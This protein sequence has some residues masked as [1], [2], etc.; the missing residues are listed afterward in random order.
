MSKRSQAW[1]NLEKKAAEKLFGTRLVRGDD[2]GLS[3]LDVEHDWLAIDCKWRSTL[4]TASWFKKLEKDN[5]KIYGK[6]R[7]VPILVIKEKNMRSELVVIDIDDFVRIV[8]D[9]KYTIE[10]K[11][12]DN[13]EE[14]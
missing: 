14:A 9:K 7:K 11:E 3:M 1:K 8:N 12:N 13:G 4:A 6:G 10:P 2:F 5:E